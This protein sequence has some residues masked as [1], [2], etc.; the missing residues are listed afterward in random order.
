ML[1]KTTRPA[2][3]AG[4]SISVPG[5]DSAIV[6]NKL[7]SLLPVTELE[8]LLNLSELVTV[9]TKKIMWEPE[10]PIE[11]AHFPED[12]V[13]SL[14]TTLKNGDTVEAMTVGNDGFAG[15]ALFHGL[16]SSRLRAIGQITGQSRRIAAEDF[17]KLAADCEELRRV[18]HNYSQFV[19]ET[20]SQSAAC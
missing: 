13:I 19:F 12:C 11:F 2:V 9:E 1:A 20:V 16:P 15:I 14:V 17:R 4:P 6:R 10:Q 18:L 7:L 8:T 5:R 3:S